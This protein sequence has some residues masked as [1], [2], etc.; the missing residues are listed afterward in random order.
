LILTEA[1]LE[2]WKQ[3]VTSTL[4]PQEL[5]RKC[6]RS[7]CLFPM[8]MAGG[9]WDLATFGASGSGSCISS[10]GVTPGSA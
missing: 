4:R 5:W 2:N 7:D 1:V 8:V 3:G 6:K 9:V 10:L